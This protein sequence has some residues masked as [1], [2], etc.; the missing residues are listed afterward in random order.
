[1]NQ[2]RVSVSYARAL[3]D[4]ANSKGLLIEVYAQSKKLQQFMIQNPEIEQLL[5]SP[6]IRISR[7]QKVIET[8]LTEYAPLLSTLVILTIRNQREKHLPIIL[9][10]FQKLYR[11]QLGVAKVMIESATELNIN[12]LKGISSYLSKKL[13]KEIE[14]EQRV[15]QALIGGFTLTIE[16]KFMDKSVKGELELFRKK[17]MRTD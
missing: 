5:S 15:N 7:K 6:G 14:I 10:V 3:F 16:D 4:W 12:T 2:G 17:L 8:L 1:M 11:E 9:L 13:S